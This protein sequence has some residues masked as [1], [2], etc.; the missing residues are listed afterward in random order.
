M[1]TNSI[2]AYANMLYGLDSV[3]NQ[4]HGG[5]TG[6]KS[7]GQRNVGSDTVSFSSQAMEKYYATKNGPNL[8]FAADDDESP[9][10]P[11][12]G[13]SAESLESGK[14]FQNMDQAGL[15]AFLKSDNFAQQAMAYVKT[16][17]YDQQTKGDA[18]DESYDLLSKAMDADARVASGASS[19]DN[20]MAAMQAQSE[21]ENAL[22]NGKRASKKEL[23]AE[24]Q[25]AEQDIKEMTA[26]YEQIMSGEVSEEEKTRL[27]QPIY[28]RLMD[29]FEE[30]QGLKTQAKSLA[31]NTA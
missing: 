11:A 9:A 4:G 3:Y 6:E 21:S 25:K 19:K 27:S 28:K 2:A 10:S 18:D 17:A 1:S 22:V 5:Y 7:V 13:M 30:L 16:V 15:L 23:S 20:A 29:R 31:A 8:S 14:N 24:I 26:R 12:G